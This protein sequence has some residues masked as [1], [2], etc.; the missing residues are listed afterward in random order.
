MLPD[1]GDQ[2]TVVGQAGQHAPRQP[3]RLRGQIDTSRFFDPMPPD[4]LGRRRQAEAEASAAVIGARLLWPGF[5]I[6]A[7]CMDYSISSTGTQAEQAAR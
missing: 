4:E 5:F 7:S 1:V 3:G 2:R 6:G